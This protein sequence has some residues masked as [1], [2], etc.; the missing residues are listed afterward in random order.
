[1]IARIRQLSHVQIFSVLVLAILGAGGVVGLVL[2]QYQQQQRSNAS[3]GLIVSSALSLDQ[4]AVGLGGTITGTV[5]YT[6][7]GSSSVFVSYVAIAGRP[8]GWTHSGGP[9]DNFSPELV[10]RTISPGETVT[11]TASRKIASSDPVGQWYAYSTYE[12]ANGWHDSSNVYFTVSTSAPTP[13][14]ATSVPVVNGLVLLNAQTKSPIKT[15][16]NNATVDLSTVGT[17]CLTIRAT[18]TP[19]TVGSV[20]FAYDGN[21][22]YSIDNFAPYDLGGDADSGDTPKCMSL[23]AGSHVLAAT[24]YSGTDGSGDLGLPAVIGFT[25]VNSANTPTNTPVPTVTMMPTETIT[26]T[27]SVQHPTNT[28]MPTGN[29]TDTPA[30]TLTPGANDTSV[31]LDLLLHGLGKGGDNAN[32]NGTGN[33]SPVH[34][35]RTVVVQ[36]YDSNNNLVATNQGNVIYDTNSGSFKG[37]V[38]LGQNMATGA[39]TVKVK[40]DQYLRALVPGIQTLTAGQTNQLPQT[41]LIAGDINGDNQINILDYNIL[42][43]CYSDLLPPVSCATGDEVLSD[44]D[45]DGHVNQFDYNL[46]LREL[47]N[48]TGQ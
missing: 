12:D 10:N 35:Q 22:H 23:A 7:T 44:L 26:P 1:M 30:P 46:F 3:G 36:A 20:V 41:T 9:F 8:P 19:S 5:S 4:S 25:V 13:T 32:P 40:S 31:G 15:L 2:S 45:D 33:T 29:P 14:L 48:S 39:Y 18:T 17:S 6:N 37:S 27:S 34:T 24:P 16:S 43:G 11:L 42:M 21:T 28:P 47:S 38:D